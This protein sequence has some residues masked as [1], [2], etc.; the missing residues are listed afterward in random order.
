MEV[1]CCSGMT[2]IAKQAVHASG[3]NGPLETIV[4]T[5]DGQIQTAAPGGFGPFGR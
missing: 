4:I 3:L 5:R 1:P 2:V